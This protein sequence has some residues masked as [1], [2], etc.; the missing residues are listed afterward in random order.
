MKKPPTLQVEQIPG[1][2]FPDRETAQRAALPL[3]SEHLQAV[4]HELLTRGDLVNVNGT[5]IKNRR[6]VNRSGSRY[7]RNGYSIPRAN[8]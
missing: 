2:T 8:P 3:L 5:I 7:G 6:A 4:L 1:N